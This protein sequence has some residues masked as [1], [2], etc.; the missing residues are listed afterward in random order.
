MKIQRSTEMLHPL[1]VEKIKI[2]Q[3]EIIDFHNL[4]IRLFETGRD[5][6]R[7]AYLLDKGKTKDLFSKHLYN[8]ENDPPLLATAIDY[9]FYDK[10]WSWN[11]RDSTIVSWYLIFGNL[12]LDLFPDLEWAGVNRKSTNYCHFQLKKETL[13]RNLNEYPCVCPL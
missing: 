8:L 7:H 10:K 4:P 3:K 11:L 13:M 12:V 9:V 2:I 1:L 5:H 6:E